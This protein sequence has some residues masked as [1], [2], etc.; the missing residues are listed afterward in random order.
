[1]KVGEVMNRVI[2]IDAGMEVRGA[3]KVMS[4]KGIGCLVV[5]KK[6]KLVG[7]I[8]ERDII[9]NIGKIGGKVSSIMSKGVVTIDQTESLD[10]AAMLMSE[11]KIKK[12]PVIHKG[13]LVGII[14][15]TDII[16]NSDSLNENFLFE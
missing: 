6:D 13:K 15:A 5:M 4:E 7:I 8:T 1:M 11:K 14:T 2:V 12:L 3:S 16:A 9:K 10:D